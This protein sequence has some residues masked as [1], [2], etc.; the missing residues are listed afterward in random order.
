MSIYKMNINER[1]KPTIGKNVIENLTVGMYNDPRFVY[2]EYVQNAV[3]QI[4]IAKKQKL[5]QSDNDASIYIKIDSDNKKVVIEDNA[6]GIEWQRVLPL[7]GNIAQSTKN[8]YENKGFRGIGR[9]SGL[10]YCEKL[11]FE[12]SFYGEDRKSTVMWDSKRLKEIILDDTIQINTAELISIMTNYSFL[13]ADKG[14]HYFKVI[15]EN[16]TNEVLL[17]IKQVRDYL[18]MVASV[19]FAYRN[20][21]HNT[22][23]EKDI[24][25]YKIVLNGENIVV[26]KKASSI[27]CKKSLSLEE[28]AILQKVYYVINTNRSIVSQ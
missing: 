15:M 16:V 22:A 1:Y 9:L 8:R 25:E 14:D 5:Y 27:Y 17:D 7:L 24:V 19:P 23:Q 26:D 20:K 10:G 6:I 4:D 18:S 2:R 28:E 3:D 11:I 13:D 12:T 21:I